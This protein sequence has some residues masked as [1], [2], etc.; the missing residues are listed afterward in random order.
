MNDWVIVEKP[1]EESMPSIANSLCSVHSSQLRLDYFNENINYKK[2]NKYYLYINRLLVMY[3]IF[4][5]IYP[6]ITYCRYILKLL[7]YYKYIL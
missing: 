7:K 1:I 6:N 5:L 2:D 3:Y 4:S